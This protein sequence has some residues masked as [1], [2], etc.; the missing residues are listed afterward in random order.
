MHL[1]FLQDNVNNY[2]ARCAR[3]I[4]AWAKILAAE[5]RIPFQR[6]LATPLIGYN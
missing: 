4:G 2:F 3:S 6:I 1:S 5:F